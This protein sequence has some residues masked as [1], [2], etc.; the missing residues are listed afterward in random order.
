MGNMREISITECNAVFGG[1]D[2]VVTGLRRYHDSNSF[3]DNH[4]SSGGGGF[5]GNYGT[6]GAFDLDSMLRSLGL[7]II[8]EGDDDGDGILNRDEEIVVIGDRTL[9]TGFKEVPGGY[10]MYELKGDGTRGPLQFTPWYADLTCEIYDSHQKAIGKTS[11]TYGYLATVIGVLGNG[12]GSGA[13][14]AMGL[15]AE[16]TGVNKKPAHCPG[17]DR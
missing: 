7:E 3:Q 10:Y 8:D 13:A 15:W 14:T 5:L 11:S 2:I 17:P 1:T 6:G 9:P 16:G 12:A 4:W